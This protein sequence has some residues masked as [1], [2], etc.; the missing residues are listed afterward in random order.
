MI[1]GLHKWAQANNLIHEDSIANLVN[2]RIAIDGVYWLT[3]R[4]R[5]VEPQHACIGGLPT[6][7][8]PIIRAELQRF[9]YGLIVLACRCSYIFKFV[10]TDLLHQL[11]TLDIVS[12]HVSYSLPFFPCW[13]ENLS[14]HISLKFNFDII[15]HR[16]ANISPVFVFP[17]LVPHKERPI[18]ADIKVERRAQYVSHTNLCWAS[19]PRFAHNDSRL[20]SLGNVL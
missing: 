10:V 4:I 14:S 2:T 11:C 7:L 3:S 17:G 18:N 9:R 6:T 8:I 16:A 19:F 13:N 1:R 20:Q 5:I 12:C 15:F